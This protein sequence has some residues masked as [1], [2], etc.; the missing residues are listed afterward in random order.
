MD[1]LQVLREQYASYKIKWER[2][3]IVMG[4]I[5]EISGYQKS[6]IVVYLVCLHDMAYLILPTANHTSLSRGSMVHFAFSNWHLRM[7]G[8][9]FCVDASL[10]L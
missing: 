9:C 2:K 6:I 8:A 7:S 1:G 5:S 4:K 10:H 3:T